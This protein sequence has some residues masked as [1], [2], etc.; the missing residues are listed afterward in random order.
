M[1]ITGTFLRLT[2]VATLVVGVQ[3]L[4]PGIAEAATVTSSSMS[5]NILGSQWD[6]AI[7]PKSSLEIRNYV[8]PDKGG[9]DDSTGTGT[10]Y[11]QPKLPAVNQL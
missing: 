1:D 2:S 4:T 5:G 10:R 8:P 9:P 7:A 11:R 3:L 6:G